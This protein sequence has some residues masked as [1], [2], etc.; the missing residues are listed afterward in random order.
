MRVVVRVT[1]ATGV[2]GLESVL[3]CLC[4]MSYQIL[5]SSLEVDSAFPKSIA[6]ACTPTNE[7][8]QFWFEK[9]QLSQVCLPYC[10]P[11]C[12]QTSV[13]ARYFQPSPHV[14]VRRPSRHVCY[15]SPLRYLAWSQTFS[16]LSRHFSAK[17]ES[18]RGEM[19][20]KLHLMEYISSLEVDHHVWAD[21]GTVTLD[22]VVISPCLSYLTL[23][24]AE[25]SWK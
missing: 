14:Q 23:Y 9:C 17:A 24:V 7:D 20:W 10:R 12:Q 21:R 6:W 1:F 16:F 4:F 22:H 2:V 5:P 19:W 8:I 15:K 13:T 18:C 3:S 25:K 11:N